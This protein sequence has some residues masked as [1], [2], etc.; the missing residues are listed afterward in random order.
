MDTPTP[1]LG[2]ALRTAPEIASELR[3]EFDRALYAHYGTQSRPDPVLATLFHTLAVQVARVYEEAESVFPATVLDDLVGVLGMPPRLAHPAQTVVHFTRIDQRERITPETE[4]FGA[5]RTGEQVGFAPDES[6]EIA[7]TQLVF[8]AVFEDGRLHAVPG[9]RVPGG[10][11]VP[12]GSTPLA[13]WE[14]PPALYLAFRGD[15]Q[16][17]GGMGLYVDT[18]ADSPAVAA[19]LARSPW[20]L[21]D[22]A[23]CVWEEGMLRG[24]P[25]RGGVQRL[26]W[27]DDPAPDNAPEDALSRV[28]RLDDGV[29]GGQL[30]IFPHVPPERRALCAI[31]PGWTRPRAASSRRAMPPRST[32][33]WLGCASRSRPAWREWRTRCSA[34]SST[35]SPPP[36]WRCGTSRS[37]S[38][39]PA[40]WSRSPPRAT[41]TA[42]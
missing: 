4:L 42:T 3:R 35:A 12:P 11:P 21:L 9:A 19:A 22:G 10:P 41:P 29:Y 13:A 25:G 5:T 27:L 33:R 6:I 14:S 39:A 2:P 36:T 34:W 26:S 17:L 7:P 37:S 28:L 23:G 20:Q 8:A 1:V 32:S 38:T 15:A 16:H 30:W 40:A 31:P 24:R 18:S